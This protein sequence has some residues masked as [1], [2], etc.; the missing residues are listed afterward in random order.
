MALFE[1][2]I[3]AD[4]LDPT[5]EEFETRFYDAGC[6]DATIAFQKGVIIIDFA[7]E[8]NSLEAAVHSAIEQV[9][10]TKTRIIR[11]EPEPL[12]SL[13]DIAERAGLTKAAISLY[14]TGQRGKGFPHP[15]ARVTSE[16]PLWN[17]AD[18]ASWLGETGKLDKERVAEA[19]FLSMVNVELSRRTG[20]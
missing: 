11:I 7:R 14:A 16:S 5:D 12:V 13:T 9:G 20:A 10:Q 17:W 6:D 15:V 8:S 18:V 2:T 3:V 1:F 4:G 19:A